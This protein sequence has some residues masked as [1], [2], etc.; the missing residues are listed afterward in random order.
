MPRLIFLQGGEDVKKRANNS[1]FEEVVKLSRAK[2]I[3][4]IPWTG[5]DREKESDYRAIFD[6]YF[7]DV[8]FREITFLQRNDEDTE[9][10]TKFSRADVL[11]LPGGDP[12]ILKREI[13]RR[14]LQKRIKE[15]DGIIVGNSAGA[16][17]LSRRG[18]GSKDCYDGFGIVD[19]SVAVHA[20]TQSIEEA[21]GVDGAIIGIPEGTWIVIRPS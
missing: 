7:H 20:T 19:I 18:C 9:I 13:E 16:I 10:E 5:D 17:V 14:S 21:K 6:E 1:M 11:Y 3:L 2:S 4:V 8:G 15:F 12:E